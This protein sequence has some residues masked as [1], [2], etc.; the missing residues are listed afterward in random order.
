[1]H[2]SWK[3][4]HDILAFYLYLYGEDNQISLNSVSRYIGFNDTGSLK[5][6]IK[7]FQAVD[8]Q[9][10]GLEHYA[11]LTK[12]VYDN[13]KNKDPVIHRKKC[14]EIMKMSNNSFL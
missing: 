13:Y 12:Q 1:M 3:E 4:E 8:G 11:K 5:M 9:E 7:N 14:L 10:N 6:R 2:H